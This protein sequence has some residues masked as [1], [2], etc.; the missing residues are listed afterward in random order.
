M[1][2]DLII[3]NAA[4]F[5]ASLLQAA[6]GIGFGIFAGPILLLV[7]NDGAAVQIS[8]ILNLLIAVVLAPGLM[9]E[10]DRPLLGRL[11][12]GSL[13]GLPI[14]L[15]IFLQVSVDVLKALAGLAVLFMALLAS[16]LCNSLFKKPNTSRNHKTGRALDGATGLVSGAM[17]GALAMPGPVVAARMVAMSRPKA[18]TR[19]TILALFVL[20]YGAALLLQA[21]MA[22]ISQESLVL[23]LTLAPATILGVLAGRMTASRI[24]EAV[25]RWTILLILVATAGG[26]LY[27]SLW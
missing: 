2:H 13:V 15:W 10:V 8:V 17:C 3:L 5:L 26:L 11:A 23:T 7:L 21:A 27:D 24:S 20:S 1:S 6:T 16:G 14:G 9:K 4:V 12:V 25:F 22:G 18:T 19:A